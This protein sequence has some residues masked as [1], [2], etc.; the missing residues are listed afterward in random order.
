MRIDQ[1]RA[2]RKTATLAER[3]LWSRLRNRQIVNLKFRRQETIADRI[4][5]FYCAEA[6]L[7]IELDGS[8]HLRHFS[9]PADLDKELELYEKGIRILRFTNDAVLS[10]LDGVLNEI[11]YAIRPEKSLWNGADSLDPEK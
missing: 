3:R 2:L 4:V 1:A 6:K 8:G 5:D 9:Q 10:N 11:I 7:A